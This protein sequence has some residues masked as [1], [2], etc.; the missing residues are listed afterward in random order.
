MNHDNKPQMKR[1][2]L[3]DPSHG[4][5]ALS[6]GVKA[7]QARNDYLLQER[8]RLARRVVELESELDQLASQKE[9]LR[10]AL[11]SIAWYRGP[12][13]APALAEKLESIALIALNTDIRQRAKQSGENQ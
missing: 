1:A 10:E 11:D 9:R 12:G 13:E 5:S 8:D 3:G 4:D 7:L 6:V 2:D